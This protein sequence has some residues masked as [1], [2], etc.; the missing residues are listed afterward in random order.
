[1]RAVKS[2]S[3]DGIIFSTPMIYIQSSYLVCTDFLL[4]TFKM[5]KNN[6]EK[7]T[8]TNGV[9]KKWKIINPSTIGFVLAIL[10]ECLKNESG[11][12]IKGSLTCSILEEKTKEIT[13]KELKNR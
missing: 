12:L 2:F 6:I 3:T 8:L 13:C 5:G 10:E 4:V 1:M 11:I 7:I 9:S